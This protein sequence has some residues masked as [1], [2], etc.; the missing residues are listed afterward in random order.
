MRATRW[1]RRR[2]GGVLSH[3]LLFLVIV[4][5]LGAL[6]WMLLLPEYLTRQIQSRTGFD[7]TVSSLSCNP[8]TGRLTIRG[9]VLT[10]PASFTTGDFLQLR[11]FR[12][13][14]D[15]WSLLSDRVSLDELTL[16]IRRIALVRRGDGR[17]NADLFAQNLGFV[18]IPAMTPASRPT[19][20]VAP[21]TPSEVAPSPAKKFRIMRLA[22]RV[23][24]LVLADYSGAAPDV[25][26]YDLAVDQH[27]ENVTEPKQILVPE[28]LRRVAA[29]NLGPI[30]ARLVPGDLGRALGDS[31][32]AAARSGEA[33]IKDAG[34]QATDLLHGLREKLEQSRK[35]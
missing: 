30:L 1:T 3:L 13:V 32:R 35:P 23:D 5:A 34:S 8:F 17:S 28:V 10:N 20:T 21:S 9:L 4:G 19:P 22:I 15:V 24:Q 33:L 2:E 25:K 14:G 6:A 27:Y 29:E 26:Q 16:D 18:P 11:E 12:A 31:A 7:A